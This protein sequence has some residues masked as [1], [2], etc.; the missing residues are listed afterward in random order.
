VRLQ[1]P[2]SSG[3]DTFSLILSPAEWKDIHGLAQFAERGLEYDCAAPYVSQVLQYEWE[4]E[5]LLSDKDMRAA[6][7]TIAGMAET[8]PLDGRD[9]GA[10]RLMLHKEEMRCLLIALGMAVDAEESADLLYNANREAF[11]HAFPKLTASSPRDPAEDLVHSLRCGRQV[12]FQ[13]HVARLIQN[14]VMAGSVS[15]VQPDGQLGPL[16]NLVSVCRHGAILFHKPVSFA[17]RL[18]RVD[19]WERIASRRRPAF[20]L[21]NSEEKLGGLDRP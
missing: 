4:P 15:Q 19:H 16:E 20:S 21:E 2:E 10:V 8:T 7:A 13:D 18:E 5:E 12:V 9:R 6:F 3:T 1:I 11:P 14:A 17:L